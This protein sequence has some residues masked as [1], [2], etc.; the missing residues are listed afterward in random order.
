MARPKVITLPTGGSIKLQDVPKEL[1]DA[2]ENLTKTT[3][4]VSATVSSD[5]QN[6]DPVMD[7]NSPLDKVALG[8]VKTGAQSFEIVEV[9]YNLNTR[10][11][12]VFQVH[13]AGVMNSQAFDKFRQFVVKNG[14]T[15]LK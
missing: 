14:F 5:Y 10:Q 4:D 9:K 11:A 3:G 13:N 8:L 15:N 2:I 6:T 7:V 1:S 12:Q